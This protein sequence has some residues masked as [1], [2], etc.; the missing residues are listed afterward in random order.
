MH[1][2]ARRSYI[3]FHAPTFKPGHRFAAA[4]T[5]MQAIITMKTYFFFFTRSTAQNEPVLFAE[6]LYELLPAVSPTTFHVT[7]DKKVKFDR[8]NLTQ[9]SDYW[10]QGVLFWNAKKGHVHGHAF[11][12]NVHKSTQIVHSFDSSDVSSESC[13]QFLIE[14][15]SLLQAD[16]AYAHPIP[17]HDD[18]ILAEDRMLGGSTSNN[19]RQW[20]PGV[21]WAACYG[22]L[23]K[24][25]FFGLNTLLGLKIHE[26]LKVNSDMVYCQITSDIQ[27]ILSNAALVT[28]ARK[29]FYN[30][31]GRSAF[32]D[33]LAPN[34]K[35]KAPEYKKP[36]VSQNTAT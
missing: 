8:D 4:S 10:W 20:L 11:L 12:G 5:T 25:F 9:F 30:A 16:Y 1:D 36:V 32:F 27:E 31:F 13:K 19:I 26:V 35:G 23:Y 28:D 6:R 29:Q 3:R 24:D 22:K 7:E 15:A 14:T 18:E 17:S 33:P 21:P 2:I 34:I